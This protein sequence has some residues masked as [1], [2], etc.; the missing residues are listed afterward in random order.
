VLVL[1]DGLAAVLARTLVDSSPASQAGAT[2]R[3]AARAPVSEAECRAL[4]GRTVL[5]RGQPWQIVGIFGPSAGES[6]ECGGESRP[7]ALGVGAGPTRTAAAPAGPALEAIVAMPG[8]PIVPQLVVTA[9]RIEDVPEL[10]GRV[11]RWLGARFGR[12]S[13]GAG[14]WR[15]EVDLGSY[16]RESNAVREGMLLFRMLMTAITGIS[17]VVGGVGIMN[18]LLASVTERTREIGISKAVGARKS[19]VLAQYL[20][21]SVA[22]STMGAVLGTALG[23]GVAQVV[24]IVM[25]AR[26]GVTVHAGF[27]LSTFLV[28]VGAPVVV[29]LCFGLYP[30]LRAARLSPIE[31]IR[32]E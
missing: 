11:E 31:A 29:G 18:V 23:I 8:R 4:V 19:D 3:T 1:S 6:S 17:L 13:A 10:R 16:E 22:I 25:R 26:S 27:S 2:R 15:D 32:H 7:A 12:D 30:A 5:V 14:G 20:A 21:E 9:E 28:A 24:A